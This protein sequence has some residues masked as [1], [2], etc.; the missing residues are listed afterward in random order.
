MALVILLVWFAMRTGDELTP[1]EKTSTAISGTNVAS[2][3]QYNATLTALALIEQATQTQVHI[4]EMTG[5]AIVFEQQT[6]EAVRATSQAETATAEA[7][8]QQTLAAEQTA[9]QEAANVGAT[10][11]ADA[12]RVRVRILDPQGNVI[13]AV[14]IR[15]YKDDGDEVFTPADR[16]NPAGDTSGDTG[17]GDESGGG[18]DAGTVTGEP[19]PIDFG[20]IAEARWSVVRW[21]SGRSPARRA[22]RS[23]STRLRATRS[24]WTCSWN[25]SARTAACWSVTMTAGMRPT[26]RFTGFTLPQDGRYS[27]RVSSVASPGPYTLLLSRGLSIPSAPAEEPAVEEAAPAR[28]PKRLPSPPRK[29]ARPLGRPVRE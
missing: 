6:Q 13:D 11:T 25:W 21:P 22:T 12:N 16:L 15:L 8:A 9:T 14:T 27:I 29:M 7:V 24:R 4:D 3:L 5:T 17:T 28:H 19:Q 18:G 23:S 26:R 2:E 10:A 20:E 1:N